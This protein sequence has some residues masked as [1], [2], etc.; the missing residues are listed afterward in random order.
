MDNHPEITTFYEPNR[1]VVVYDSPDEAA[2]KARYYLDHP[3]ERAVI[4][5]AGHRRAAAEHRYVDRLRAILN[6]AGFQIR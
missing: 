6:T 3:Q 2:D 4:A 5:F 1:E